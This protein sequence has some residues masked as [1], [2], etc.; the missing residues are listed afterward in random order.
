MFFLFHK[1]KNKFK[2]QTG[3][4]LIELMI[5]IGIVTLVTG[6]VLVRYSSFNNT[7]LLQAQAYELALDIREAQVLGVSVGGKTGAFRKAFGI[8]INLDKP[9]TYILFQD[10]PS[11]GTDG[12]YDPGEEVGDI[13][14]VDPRFRILDIC[15]GVGGTESCSNHSASITFKRPDFDARIITDTATN[16][17]YIKIILASDKDTTVQ[18]NVIVYQ[19]GQITVQ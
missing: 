17:D 1:N 6:I 10:A 4:S 15:V 3:F 2:K 5:S 8:Y 16:P 13:Y 11:S 14:T 9:N 18:K 12:L 7:V 19:S